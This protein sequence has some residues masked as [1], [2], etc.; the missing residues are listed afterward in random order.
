[1]SDVDK[2]LGYAE[3]LIAR[4]EKN[5][6]GTPPVMIAFTMTSVCNALANIL[7][8]PTITQQQLEKSVLLRKRERKIKERLDLKAF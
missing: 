7:L 8:S 5:F 1:M 6:E 4:T 3:I 2:V